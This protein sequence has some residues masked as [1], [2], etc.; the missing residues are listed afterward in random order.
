MRVAKML[1][2]S[3]GLEDW[4]LVV[5]AMVLALGLERIERILNPYSVVDSRFLPGQPGPGSE[6]LVSDLATSREPAAV[7]LPPH[8]TGHLLER[9]PAL[10]RAAREPAGPC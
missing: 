1:N 8:C 4:R 6:S 10:R 2:S 5:A 7:D 9:N 3:Q